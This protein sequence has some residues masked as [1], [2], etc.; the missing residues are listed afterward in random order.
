MTARIAVARVPAMSCWGASAPQIS[1]KAE[2]TTA[3]PKTRMAGTGGRWIPRR[4]STAAGR[5]TAKAR[6]ILSTAVL[7]PARRRAVNG[8]SRRRRAREAEAR[9]AV[10]LQH[11]AV[12][13]HQKAGAPGAARGGLVDDALLHP[14]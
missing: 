13:H 14:D 1:R 5:A 2:A 9:L 3:A 12:H 7:Q 11:A 6:T 10:L 8:R 4:R